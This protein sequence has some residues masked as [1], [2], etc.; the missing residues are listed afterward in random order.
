LSRD[1]VAEKSVV[2]TY[3]QQMNYSLFYCTYFNT[4]DISSFNKEC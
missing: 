2:I 1:Y 3:H 4:T